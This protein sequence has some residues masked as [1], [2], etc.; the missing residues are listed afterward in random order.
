MQ[1][2]KVV[3]AE[4]KFNDAEPGSFTGYGAIF[5]NE[6]S[7]GDIIERGAFAE[8]LRQNGTVRPWLWQHRAD[9][10]IGS[11]TLSE[12][13]RGLRM[14]GRLL[15]DVAQARECYALMKAGVV[16]GASIGYETLKSKNGGGG[17]R[18]LQAVR[19]W[20]V[21]AVTFPANALA[22]IDSVR[23]DDPAALALLN[24][25]RSANI[26]ARTKAEARDAE[27]LRAAINSLRARVRA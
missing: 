16:T 20:E 15:L 1:T 9:A 4:F 25:L 11:V 5:G 21:S 13:A 22:R 6:D 19:L 24:A 27:R 10:P 23:G 7:Q 12:D 2:Q 14:S 3:A 8:D 26:A 18:M 17:T